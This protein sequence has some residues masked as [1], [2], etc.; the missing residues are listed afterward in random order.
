MTTT[1]QIVTDAMR[2]AG[3]LPIGSPLAADELEEGIRRL[4]VLIK[5]FFGSELGEPLETVNFGSYGLV[6]PY[7]VAEDM[8]SDINSVYVPMNTRLLVN[9]SAIATAYLHPNP[10]DG[11]R[12]A[13]V[14]NAGNLSTNTL[15][16]NAN[17]RK[18]E[19]APTAVLNTNSLVREWFYRADLGN[20][21]RITDLDA[22]AA[23]PFPS[24]FDDLLST[25]LAYRLNP[26]FGAE[27]SVNLVQILNRMKQM[28]RARY[29]Q[30]VEQ[31]VELGLYR[32]PSNRWANWS[33]GGF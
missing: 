23:S 21:V 5:G 29:R 7:A 32:L 17:G 13:V 1:R 12:L 14:D 25:A 16:L 6:S 22:D 30:G 19:L 10:R 2:E 18:I 24:E 26:R 9:S 11:A 3:I 4:N 28:F 20:W 15:T 33:G 27:T 8:S 31:P